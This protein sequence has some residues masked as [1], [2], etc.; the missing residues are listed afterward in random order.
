VE[1]KLDVVEIAARR[2]ITLGTVGAAIGLRLRTGEMRRAAAGFADLSARTPL[3]DCQQFRIASITKLF[4]FGII[5]KLHD[6]GFL[7]LDT[8]VE[9][10][11][12]DLPYG[13]AITL[14]QILMQTA[15]LPVWATDRAEEIPPAERWTPEE[16][17]AFHYERTPAQR[18]GRAMV[19]ANVGSRVAGLIAERATGESIAD[20]IA[21]RFLVPLGL[22]DTIPSGARGTR[23]GKL[24]CGYAF[25][26]GG[27]PRDVTWAVPQNWLW[28]GG[29]MYSTV[30][31]LTRWVHALFGGE[32]L[33]PALTSQVVTER[34][35][36]GFHGSTMTHHGLGGY[37]VHAR[38]RRA[39]ISGQ[40]ARLRL[41]PRVR[42]AAPSWRRGAH[43]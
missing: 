37:G 24:P 26:N 29:D 4:V 32:V 7:D 40:D 11:L 9:R 8:A 15:G 18:P 2:L 33:S 35:S 42:A 19:Y 30:D 36:G 12:P 38:L 43:E 31:D 21:G 39:R 5:L 25:E 16:V 28:A 10:W 6:E 14:R 1:S 23:P 3:T 34:V 27:R 13:D 17:I 20:L 41:D 22:F